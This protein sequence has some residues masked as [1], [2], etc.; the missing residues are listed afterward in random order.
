MRWSVKHE[1]KSQQRGAAGAKKAGTESSPRWFAERAGEFRA[2]LRRDLPLPSDDTSH[3]R[4]SSSDSD[5]NASLSPNNEE[6]PEQLVSKDIEPRDSQKT[7]IPDLWLCDKDLVMAMPYFGDHEAIR[8]PVSSNDNPEL[9]FAP[10]LIDDDTLLYEH[11]FSNV[12]RIVSGFDSHKNPLRVY[13]ASLMSRY[14]MI[15]HCV[16][17]ISA[18]HLSQEQKRVNTLALQHQTQAVSCLA[19]EVARLEDN[20]L[21]TSSGELNL[22]E[23]PDST[24]LTALL[25]GTIMLGM[26]SVGKP[27]DSVCFRWPWH[28]NTSLGMA[29]RILIG[30]STS[31]GGTDAIP[32][33]VFPQQFPTFLHI[34]RFR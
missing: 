18:A 33:V 1:L 19:I 3:Y 24:P 32:T 20:A 2:S 15:H 27:F 29:Q 22:L 30:I 34:R 5:I 31:P 4:N 6:G 7:A 8:A 13:V 17:S 12:C 26:T 11:Y 16:L 10:A 9:C 21:S 14:S 25:L 23:R 28:V